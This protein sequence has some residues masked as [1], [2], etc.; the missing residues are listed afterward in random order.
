M[1][2]HPVFSVSLSAWDDE[3]LKAAKQRWEEK[4]EKKMVVSPISDTTKWITSKRKEG[5]ENWS[6]NF[7][8][9][10]FFFFENC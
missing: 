2:F 8:D 5:R 3:Y 9:N 10:Y 1:R 6:Q 7:S 4:N